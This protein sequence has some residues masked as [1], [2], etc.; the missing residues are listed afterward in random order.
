MILYTCVYFT[1]L[2]AICIYCDHFVSQAICCLLFNVLSQLIFKI[3]MQG[4]IISVNILQWENKVWKLDDLCTYRRTSF[5]CASL[6]TSQIFHFL[7]IKH[8]WQPWVDKV[9]QHHLSNGMCSLPVSDSYFGNSCNISNFFIFY[10]N[11]YGD[12]S[13]VIFYVTTMTRWRLRWW[14]A[15]F[16]NEVFLN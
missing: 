13:S 14:L 8:L 1:Y 15:F 7:Q 2:L 3:T 9:Y 11:C 6:C 5:Y 10:C 12:L 16:N 4:R